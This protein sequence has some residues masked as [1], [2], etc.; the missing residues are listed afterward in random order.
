MRTYLSPHSI[1]CTRANLAS[2]LD[3]I[4]SFVKIQNCLMM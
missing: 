2:F 1:L 3:H 4:P